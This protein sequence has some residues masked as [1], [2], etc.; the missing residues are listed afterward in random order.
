MSGYVVGTIIVFAL[1]YCFL[2]WEMHRAS[3]QFQGR[4]TRDGQRHFTV[5]RGQYDVARKGWREARRF[6]TP[7]MIELQRGRW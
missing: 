3:R 6:E 5:T 1:A 4:L 2:L 7:G